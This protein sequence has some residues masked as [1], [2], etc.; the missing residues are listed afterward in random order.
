[1]RSRCWYLFEG[2]TLRRKVTVKDSFGQKSTK[3]CMVK[4]KNQEACNI[5]FG[6][7]HSY[8]NSSTQNQERI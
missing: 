6:Y 1:M 5:A 8:A 3:I 2:Q 7:G 4:A